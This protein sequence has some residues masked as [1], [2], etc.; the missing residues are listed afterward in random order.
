[1]F[2]DE[3]DLNWYDY[4]A[5][6]YDPVV[7]RFHTLDPLS[8]S[9][10][11]QS[12]FVYADNNPVNLIDFMG[13][14][15]DGYTIDEKGELNRVNDTGGKNYDVLYTKKNYNKAV[16]ETKATG[17]KNDYGNP[18]PGNGLRVSSGTFDESN[19][20]ALGE[21]KGI[22]TDNITDAKAIFKFAADNFPIEYGIVS[23]D[24]NGSISIFHTSGKEDYTETGKVAKYMIDNGVF[25]TE[26]NH[27]H[28]GG[29][30]YGTPSGFYTNG[31]PTNP[32]SGDAKT[33]KWI[34]EK[35]G[36]PSNH[37]MYHPSSGNTFQY[38]S[39]YYVR[40]K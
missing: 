2:Q 39:K 15:A 27:S 1:M 21:V 5:R 28:P 32:P 37:Y 6:F 10:N 24:K 9:F 20:I 8:E 40:K 26:D 25:L 35:N 34:D 12:P 36:A 16:N 30:E 4:G 3:L 22:L 33:S 29:T 7:G 23:G 13:M 18:E 38:D 19:M 14:N 11:N 31:E 17:E